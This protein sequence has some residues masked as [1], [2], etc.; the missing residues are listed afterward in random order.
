MLTL[1]TVVLVAPGVDYD[2]KSTPERRVIRNAFDQRYKVRGISV[3]KVVLV[4]LTRDEIVREL[5]EGLNM[6][7]LSYEHKHQTPVEYVEEQP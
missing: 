7:S 4:G 3:G 1:V 2:M 5:A 6:A